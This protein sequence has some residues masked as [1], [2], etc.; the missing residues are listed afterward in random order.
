MSVE[1]W[2]S[3]LKLCEQPPSVPQ[4]TLKSLKGSEVGNISTWEAEAGELL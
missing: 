4:D 2:R 1:R 3:E